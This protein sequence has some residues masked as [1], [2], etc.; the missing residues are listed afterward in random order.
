[1][2]RTMWLTLLVLPRYSLVLA[3]FGITCWYV[4]KHHFPTP[5]WTHEAA[6]WRAFA[7]YQDGL[8]R[9]IQLNPH[10][11]EKRVQSWLPDGTPRDVLQ[12]PKELGD[13]VVC[14]ATN[15]LAC[16]LGPDLAVWD[17]VHDCLLYTLPVVEAGFLEKLSL[18]VKPIQVRTDRP[19][20]HRRLIL[21]PNGA[22][23]AVQLDDEVVMVD[24]QQ[25]RIARRFPQRRGEVV[26]I[27]NDGTRMLSRLDQVSKPWITDTVSLTRVA[28]LELDPFIYGNC[29]SW[30]GN[31]LIIV[32]LDPSQKQFLLNRYRFDTG[33]LVSQQTVPFPEGRTPYYLTLHALKDGSVVL[34]SNYTI[35]D[36]PL[37]VEAMTWLEIRFNF[38][39]G[40]DWQRGQEH[41]QLFRVRPDGRGEKLLDG[42]HVSHARIADD[43]QL[44]LVRHTLAHEHRT[45]F[46]YAV[47]RYPFPSPWPMAVLYGLL[48]ALPLQLVQLLWQ[49]WRRRTTSS[50]SPPG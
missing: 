48:F 16:L 24:L 28:N 39:F 3:V 40:M 36:Y 44:I 22:W 14:P 26:A 7:P 37:F 47:Y 27:N 2:L 8:Y 50:A 5:V 32:G 38:R 21:S 42:K 9:L 30:D 15:R 25:Q 34:Y 10:D 43:G 11:T 35:S 23:L 20:L 1:M 31:E 46:R 41:G 18:Y 13:A 6:G 49:R 19:F 29:T 4:L 45:G 12:L 33:A 17:L